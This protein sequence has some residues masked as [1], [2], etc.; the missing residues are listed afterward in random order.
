LATHSELS[1]INCI[2][3]RRCTMLRTSRA[4][5]GRLLVTTASQRWRR[6]VLICLLTGALGF[7]PTNGRTAGLECPEIAAGSNLLSDAQIKLVASGD[8]VDVANEIYDLINRLQTEKPNISYS[9]LTDVLVA[10]YC[11]VVAGLPNLTA[12]EKWRRLRQFDTILQRQLA[13]NIMP[14]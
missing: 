13:A 5:Q 12:S 10:A 2:R 8:S 6:V 1:G 4:L 11:P 3:D 9:E 14:S 7:L